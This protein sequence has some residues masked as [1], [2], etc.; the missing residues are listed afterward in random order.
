MWHSCVV[1][2]RDPLNWLASYIKM[3]GL[4]ESQIQTYLKMCQNLG[5]DENRPYILFHRWFTS[6][7]YRQKIAARLGLE[8]SDE[9]LCRI[10]AIGG[11]SSF[12]GMQKQ[13]EAQTMDVLNRWKIMRD[14]PYFQDVLKR[15]PALLDVAVNIF[16]Y[17]PL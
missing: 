4:K 7:E 1:I 16:N 2:L 12:D 8:A 14:D 11:G 9:E 5:G 3:G 10:S 6:P 15:Y 17:C 13:G